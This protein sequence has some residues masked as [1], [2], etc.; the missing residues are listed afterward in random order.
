MSVDKFM[1][2]DKQTTEERL[3]ALEDGMR[4]LTERMQHLLMEQPE[5]KKNAVDKF[6]ENYDPKRD[7]PPEPDEK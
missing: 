1:A 6:F 4:S 7:L 5:R 3:A 2:G